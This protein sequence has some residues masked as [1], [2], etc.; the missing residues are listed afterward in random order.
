MDS[1]RVLILTQTAAHNLHSTTTT[2]TKAV[3]SVTPLHCASGV[4]PWHL[5]LTRTQYRYG[6][7]QRYTV[8][9]PPDRQPLTAPTKPPQPQR[10]LPL[11]PL[12]DG[13]ES[14]MDLADCVI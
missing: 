7:R 11:G 5:A 3:T 14:A 13:R 12:T 4:C 6:G 1:D 10:R 8:P 2:T 9:S